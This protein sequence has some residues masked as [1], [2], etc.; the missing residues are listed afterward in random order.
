MGVQTAFI[1]R[2]SPNADYAVQFLEK[3]VCTMDGL[4]TIDT[5]APLGV[6]ALKAL[7]DE[8][9]A[10]NPLIKG[11][12]ENALNGVVMPN[13][14]QMGKLWSSMKAAFETTTNGETTPE[15]A[16][17]EARNNLEK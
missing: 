17:K 5:D 15:A 4:K 12:Y 10:N 7:A 11:T 1:N 13:I 16:L 9:S 14:P 8:M 2:S 6:P 3:F